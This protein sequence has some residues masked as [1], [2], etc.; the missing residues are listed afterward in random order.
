[1]MHDWGEEDFDWEGLNDA[2]N[3]IVHEFKKW[4]IGVRQS[5]EKFGMARVY[6]TLGW[7]QLHNITHPGHCYSRYPKWL[8]KLDIYVL[9]KIVPWLNLIVIPIHKAVY[10]NAYK[11][12]CNKYPHL[13]VEICCCADYVELLDFY[14]KRCITR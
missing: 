7:Y 13:L 1:M 8:W 5:K 6:C 14:N 10:R 9:S 3:I 11:K 4:R 12:A 2:I